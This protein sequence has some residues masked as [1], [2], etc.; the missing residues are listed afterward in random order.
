MYILRSCKCNPRLP[1]TD[2]RSDHG[3]CWWSVVH[4]CN[5]S[6]TQLRKST[7]SRPTDRPWSV[8]QT[9]VRGLCPWIKT[10]LP[11]L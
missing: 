9:T 7:K 4:H 10:L 6:A 11:S 8:G 5:P 3:L 2:R 1:S